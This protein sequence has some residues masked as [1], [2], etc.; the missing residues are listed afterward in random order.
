MPTLIDLWR[1]IDPDARLLAG[2]PED[3]RRPL[4][5]I[6]RTRATPPHLPPVA[7]GELVVADRAL[8]PDRSVAPLL[9]ALTAVAAAPAGVIV[10]GVA[11]GDALE[12]GPGSGTVPVLATAATAAAVAAEAQGY[13]DHERE[14]LE[15]FALELRVAMAEAAL[16][17]LRASVPAAVAALRIRRGVA[18]A[19]AGRLLAVHARPRGEAV[20]LRF[21]ATFYGVLATPSVRRSSERRTRSGLWVAEHPVDAADGA[22]ASVWLFDDLA[23]AAIDR[24]AGEALVTTLRALLMAEPRARDDHASPATP[25]AALAASDLEQPSERLARTV[26]AVARSNGRVAPAA[27]ALGVH[28]NTVLYRLR[29][30]RDELGI[31]PRRP[32]DALRVLL[33]RGERPAPTVPSRGPPR[34]DR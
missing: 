24:I 8:V 4:R 22:A 19:R 3:L 29:R 9:E 10:S 17:D 18:V 30:A 2:D 7:P 1:A 31:D 26:L 25:T 5:G 11:A 20:A 14:L 23:F 32:D 34:R 13:L 16:A 12:P 27:R 6:V 28:R 21:T 15:R 33:E